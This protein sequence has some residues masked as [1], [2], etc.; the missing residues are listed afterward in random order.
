MVNRVKETLQNT[1]LPIGCT[2]RII[3]LCPLCKYEKKRVMEKLREENI[4]PK[5]KLE[6]DIHVKIANIITYQRKLHREKTKQNK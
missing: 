4:L 6:Y 5:E 1:E 3:Q 2:E